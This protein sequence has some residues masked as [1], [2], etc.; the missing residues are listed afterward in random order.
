MGVCPKGQFL[1]LFIIFCLATRTT[2]T[3]SVSADSLK[4]VTFTATSYPE[5]LRHGKQT[6]CVSG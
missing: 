2:R 3:S 5:K 4:M 1:S 6:I